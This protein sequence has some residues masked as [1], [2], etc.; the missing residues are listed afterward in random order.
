M[1]NLKY[2]LPFTVLLLV[3]QTAI[4]ES[5]L[6]QEIDGFED[7]RSV[8]REPIP[9]SEFFYTMCR[10]PTLVEK[11]AAATP[12]KSRHINVRVNPEGEEVFYG[13]NKLQPFPVG[14][15]IVKEKFPDS[16]FKNAESLGAMIKNESG[17]DYIY[18]DENGEVFRERKMLENCYSCHSLIKERDEVF[19]T[20]LENWGLT[21]NMIKV[22]EG[23]SIPEELTDKGFLRFI[24]ERRREQGKP[25]EAD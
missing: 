14:S 10:T 20:Y 9:V 25:P 4:A 2:L 22:P 12:H 17:W 15:V 13:G 3:L 19:R 21:G 18:K 7:W 16:E 1:N 23:G 8:T 24:W 11:L 6:I 5:N